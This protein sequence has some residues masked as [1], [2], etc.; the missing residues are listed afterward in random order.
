MEQASRPEPILVWLICIN[1][2]QNQ[3]TNHII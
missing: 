3:A 2:G 1:A